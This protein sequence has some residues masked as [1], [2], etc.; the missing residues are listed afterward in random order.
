MLVCAAWSS[1][2]RI[3]HNLRF[4]AE[5]RDRHLAFNS[6]VDGRMAIILRVFD[7]FSAVMFVTETAERYAAGRFDPHVLR[8][9]HIDPVAGTMRHSGCPAF[10]GHDG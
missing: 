1:S 6:V 9:V 3:S 10:A 5:D 2:A 8:F 7:N 4:W